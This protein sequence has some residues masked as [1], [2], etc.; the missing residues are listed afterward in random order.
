MTD[1]EKAIVMAHTG[2]VMLTGDK[3]NEFYKYLEEIFNR[4]VYTHELVILEQDIKEKSKKD[5]IN[6]CKNTENQKWTPVSES[7]PDPHE[8]VNVTVL[9]EFG[10]SKFTYSNSG[11]YLSDGWWI[12]DNEPRNED[13]SIRVIAW[14]PLPTPWKGDNKE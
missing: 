12:V 8:M 10:D 3:I 9:D 13:Q 4:P 6:L 11:Y 1:R 5:F 2:I 14:M 7:L